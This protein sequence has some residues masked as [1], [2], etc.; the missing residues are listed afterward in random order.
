M[1]AD[2]DMNS[3]DILNARDVSASRSLTVQGVDVADLISGVGS[4]TVFNTTNRFDGDG[5]TVAFTLTK[6]PVSR[7]NTQVFVNGVYQ[8]KDTYTV[9]GTILTF[10]QAPSK[11]SDNIEVNIQESTSTGTPSASGVSTSDGQDVQA[12]LDQ[13]HYTTRALF[14]ADIVAGKS[15]SDGDVVSDG[16]VLYIKSTGATAISDMGGW[17]PFGPTQAEHFPSSSISAALAYDG[18]AKLRGGVTYTVSSA[19]TLSDNNCIYCTDGRSA[20][21]KVADGADVDAISGTEVDGVTLHN[22]TIDGNKANQ[23]VA[24]ASGIYLLNTCNNIL[25]SNVEIKNT[26]GHGLQFSNGSANTGNVVS[27]CRAISCGQTGNSTE[28]TGFNGGSVDTRWVNCFADGC[29]LN[30]FK[31]GGTFENCTAINGLGGGFETGFGVSDYDYTRYIG[32]TAKDNEGDGFR[33]LG[34]G[35]RLSYV[36]CVVEG[37][38]GSGISFVNDVNGAIV[39]GCYIRNNGQD[40][41]SAA[42]SGTVGYDGIFI[43]NT[44]AH[45]ANITVTNTHFGNSSNTQEYHIFVDAEVDT[46]VVD[47]SCVFEDDARNENMWFATGNAGLKTYVGSVIGHPIVTRDITSA[48]T[49]STSGETLKTTT[50]PA[51]T[52][53]VDQPIKVAGY[54]TC[55]GTNDTKLVRFYLGATPI[56]ISSQAAGDQLDWGFEATIYR[57]G[58]T[59]LMAMV[60]TFENGSDGVLKSVNITSSFT[61]DLTFR[62]EGTVGNASDTI[63]QTFHMCEPA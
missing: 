10:S 47:G 24:T 3:Y 2:L 5:T 26:Y 14:V 7:A 8:Q 16:T 30:G 20:T 28:G 60:R 1:N 11:G 63:T 6:D 53:F 52:L 32:C 42:R 29:L 59:R 43:S 56:T 58:G 46:L 40:Y 39:D 36:N 62:T 27:N 4:G 31:A 19:V 44:S 18:T 41:A 49:S 61:A 21:I 35:D 34:E 45:P 23:T 15:W 38:G 13:S 50:L 33:N 17:L 37:N 22:L 9:S 54:G 57:N 48:S 12:K 55:S 51:Q 25:I